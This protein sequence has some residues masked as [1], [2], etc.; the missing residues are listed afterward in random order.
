ML[1]F[2]KEMLE[3]DEAFTLGIAFA[4]GYSHA[5]CQ[6]KRVDEIGIAY[7]TNSDRCCLTPWSAIQFVEVE[8]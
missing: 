4:D 6:V 7:I 3:A 2:L 8:S 5:A 1:Q